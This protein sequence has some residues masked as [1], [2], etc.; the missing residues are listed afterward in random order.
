MAD[1]TIAADEQGAYEIP[2][3]A[4]TPITVQ[5]DA[6]YRLLT[7]GIRIT[8]HGGNKPIY[9]RVNETNVGDPRATMIPAYT[10][11]DIAIANIPTVTIALVSADA[12]VVSV[13]R[14]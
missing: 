3:E 14:Q 6:Q 7:G 13:A 12:A 4:D 11:E 9:V 1:H 8:H 5:I 2:L 10:W